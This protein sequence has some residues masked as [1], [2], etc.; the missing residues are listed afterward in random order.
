MTVEQAEQLAQLARAACG[1]PLHVPAD[2]DSPAA[3][4][5]EF[6][7]TSAPHVKAMAA[8]RAEHDRRRRMNPKLGE[9]RYD[10]AALR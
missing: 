7:A 8:A 10:P 3:W 6:H 5:C 9:F 1:V 4:L 2:I